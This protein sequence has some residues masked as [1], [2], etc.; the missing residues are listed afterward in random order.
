MDK[1][2]TIEIQAQSKLKT[3]LVQIDFK[4]RKLAD[5]TT[6]KIQAKKEREQAKA[7][8]VINNRIANQKRKLKWKPIKP[9]KI[10][11][12]KKNDDL[13]SL[14][15]RKKYWP[16]CF[17]CAKWKWDNNGHCFSR[18]YRSLRRDENNCRPQWFYCCN[19]KLTGNWRH[20]LFKLNLR[21]DW[22]DVDAMQA[23]VD[24]CVKYPG[25]FNN[26]PTDDELQ[27]IHKQIELLTLSL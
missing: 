22:V 6:D 12:V 25:D 21:R 2:K 27:I 5:A 18:T 8:R 16:R 19:S 20:D 3:K 1:L 7:L 4:Y 14:Y 9:K 17:T 13:F 26:K 23:I 15:I 24:K 11:R 10:D